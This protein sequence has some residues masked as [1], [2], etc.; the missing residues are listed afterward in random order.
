VVAHTA[1]AQNPARG[2][3]DQRALALMDAV[4]A[5]MRAAKSLEV[6]KTNTIREPMTGNAQGT[7]LI[8]VQV[9]RPDRYRVQTLNA[10]KDARMNAYTTDRVS[11][12]QLR[13]TRRLEA[14]RYNEKTQQMEALPESSW[15]WHDRVEHTADE[16][17][18]VWDDD[19]QTLASLYVADDEHPGVGH[20][21]RHHKVFEPTFNW[22]R[23]IGKESWEGKSYDVVEW[24]YDIGIH[25][26]DQQVMYTQ[27]IYVGSDTLVHRVVTTTSRGHVLEDAYK[28]ITLNPELPDSTF[29]ITVKPKENELGGYRLKFAEGSTLPD[30]TL[31]AHGALGDTITFSK[32]VAGKKGAVIWFWGFH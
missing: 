1:A 2:F 32:A 18:Y 9:K 24:K 17:I 26:T 16:D 23:Y 19:I 10:D 13:L 25:P 31:P 28:S 22:I 20:D 29:A 7:R 12:G 5:K 30:F 6:V 11:N 21:W 8:K 14:Q 3:V 4:E 27:K 15:K